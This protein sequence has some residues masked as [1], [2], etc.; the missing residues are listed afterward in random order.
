MRKRIHLQVDTLANRIG[1]LDGILSGGFGISGLSE[2]HCDRHQHPD[3]NQIHGAY[4]AIRTPSN[5][6]AEINTCEY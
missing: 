2:H 1:D 5:R 6:I 3:A 4:P